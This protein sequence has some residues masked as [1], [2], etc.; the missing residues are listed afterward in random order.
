MSLPLIQGSKSEWALMKAHEW[1]TVPPTVNPKQAIVRNYDSSGDL[2]FGAQ[3]AANK[4]WQ[5]LKATEALTALCS[6]L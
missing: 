1:E 6:K 5:A 4:P 3:I 2:R